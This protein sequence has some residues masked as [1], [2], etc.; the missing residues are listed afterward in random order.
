MQTS[1][2]YRDAPALC[3]LCAIMMTEKNLFDAVVDVCGDCHGVWV[4]W[5]DGDLGHVVEQV[6]ADSARGSA[7][8]HIGPSGGA[9]PK[10]QAK[11]APEDR[12]DG[13]HLLRCGDCG[14]AFVPRASFMPLIALSHQEPEILAQ[15]SPSVFAR[16]VAVLNSLLSGKD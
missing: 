14:G 16:L 13:V 3:P 5:F 4:D 11:L 15:K 8:T 12:A 2:G 1:A 6:S 9:C 10:C 7:S